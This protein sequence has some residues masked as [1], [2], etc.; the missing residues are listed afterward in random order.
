[1]QELLMP[2]GAR[3]RYRDTGAGDDALLLV[4][5]WCSSG[6]AWERTARS[7]GRHSRVVRVDLRGHG[8]SE[9]PPSGG[10]RWR[11]F[12]GDVEALVRALGLMRVV[13]V[14]HSMGSP[15]SLELARRLPGTVAGVVAIDGLSGLGL[16]RERAATH[17]WVVAL[18]PT[19]T[20]A[21]RR[22]LVQS[23]L[24]ADERG[25]RIV[26]GDAMRTDPRAALAAYR[27]SVVTGAPRAAWRRMPQPLL[28]V[29]ASRGRRTADDVRAAIPH[30]QFGQVVGSGHYVQLDAAPQLHAMLERFLA[31]L[32]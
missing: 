9:A 28:Y 19:S 11:D 22:R 2:G 31:G 4:H 15:V 3:L 17:P 8:A 30:A 1:M 7:L 27:D 23:F 13:A 20:P 6:R 32:P 14:G 25:A 29:A 18:T 5:G 12:A 16:T 10:Y 24:P 21:T 26:E